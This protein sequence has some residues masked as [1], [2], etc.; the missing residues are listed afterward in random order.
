MLYESFKDLPRGPPPGNT[1]A[2]MEILR[3]LGPKPHQTDEFGGDFLN[4]FRSLW[5][6]END[7]FGCYLM[8]LRSL[9][10]PGMIP[11][12]FWIIHLFIIF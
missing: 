10:H 9:D 1:C 6:I 3:I 8:F 11:D 2:S 12:R 5:V 7:N 4:F